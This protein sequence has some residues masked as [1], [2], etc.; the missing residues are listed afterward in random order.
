[1]VGTVSA[2]KVLVAEYPHDGVCVKVAK[3]INS[4]RVSRM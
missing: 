2:S 3:G 4:P 1:V